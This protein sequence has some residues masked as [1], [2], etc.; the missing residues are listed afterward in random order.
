M[1]K[2]RGIFSTLPL[3]VF[4]GAGRSGPLRGCSSSSDPVS[5]FA[6]HPDVP[7]KGYAGGELG[8]LRQTYA[9][10]YLVVAYRELN[11]QTFSPSEQQALSEYWLYR[12][13]LDR[14]EE[15]KLTGMAAWN[16]VSAKISANTRPKYHDSSNCYDDAFLAAARRAEALCAK[17][18][19]ESPLVNNWM[20]AQQRVFASC[21]RA[22]DLPEP[23]IASLPEE[24][25]K[26]RAYQIAAAR[27]YRNEYDEAVAA[28]DAIAADSHS[29]WRTI[30][31]YLAA[32]ALIRKAWL[33]SDD[34][35]SLPEFQA[36]RTRLEQILADSGRAALHQQ[37]RNLLSYVVLRLDPVGSGQRLA[38]KLLQRGD[39]PDL[40]R[41]L[42]EY[43]WYL[44][45]V[46]GERRSEAST[47]KEK[48]A[49]TQ[50]DMSDWI[51]TFQNPNDD[52]ANHAFGRWQKT[53]SRAWLVAALYLLRSDDS[54]LN[55]LLEAARVGKPGTPG[56]LSLSFA[57][58]SHF[59]RLGRLQAARALLAEV[60]QQ[61][62]ANPMP[63]GAANGF[64]N[65]AA[66]LATSP[67]GFAQ[68]AYVSVVGEVGDGEE[69][70]SSHDQL[71]LSD[72]AVVLINDKI[73]VSR[74]VASQL[75]LTAD[76]EV[77]L[78]RLIRNRAM[79]LDRTDLVR[80]LGGNDPAVVQFLGA[81]S[82][83]ERRFIAVYM[84]LMSD[85]QIMLRL[86]GGLSQEEPW[87][88]AARSTEA[89]RLALP[90]ITPSWLTSDQAAAAEAEQRKLKEW[91]ASATLYCRETLAWAS[92]HP[93]D[94]RNPEALSLALGATKNGGHDD[95]SKKY[96]SAAMAFL[97]KR[98]PGNHWSKSTKY[99]Y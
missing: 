71:G 7:F 40:V 99:W 86:P 26:E 13:G 50:N 52:S 34:N 85:S 11:G 90:P 12:S 25:K 82:Q 98:Y 81:S 17:F 23:P 8:I 49:A 66:A 84:I 93:D 15:H 37:A 28:F 2:M 74:L 94:P 62:S 42:G 54:H 45:W 92:S 57:R 18:G 97:H 67:D 35:P 83:E 29:S 22:S 39:N 43:T 60:E 19:C 1:I 75:S 72:Y 10:S 73:P 95:N 44:D 31:P 16:A 21:D 91:G 51:L 9:R 68:N 5:A 55:P 53:G 36:A 76:R 3:I 30:A 87:E 96:C 47:A 46:T 63:P 41:E 59:M 69:I 56:Y 88:D 14:N 33:H 24:M 79:L 80:Q 65:A 48:A 77:E 4:F 20:Q 58:I 64:R 70:N 32:R 78:T 61:Y 89:H 27:L 38:A 6:R